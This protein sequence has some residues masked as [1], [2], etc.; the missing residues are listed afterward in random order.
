[1]GR[2]IKRVPL[3]FD[4]PRNKRWTGYVNPNHRPCPEDEKTCFH[5]Y[6]AGG[7]WL[8]A[9]IRMISLIGQEAKTAPLADQ[10]DPRHRTYPHPYLQEW[11]QAPHTGMPRSVR[12][13][14]DAKYPDDGKKSTHDARYRQVCA[15]RDANRS[16]VLPLTQELVDLVEGLAGEKLGI[17]IGANHQIEHKLQE[18]L[19]ALAGLDVGKFGVCQ[20]CGGDGMDP[21]AKEAYEAWERTDPPEGPGW[22]LWETVSE[23]SPISPVFPDADAFKRW[24]LA[25]GYSETAA[26]N[27]IKSGWAP[28]AISVNGEFYKDIESCA[29]QGEK[30]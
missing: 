29:L 24:L 22:Q 9:L 6:T 13:A 25:E 27:F 18:R 1:M 5:G 11:P 10:F 3:T 12:E 28:S 16:H 30:A 20:V 23:G 17:G 2:V 4:W 14:L 19:V 26:A 7:R 15:W 8:D 21:A